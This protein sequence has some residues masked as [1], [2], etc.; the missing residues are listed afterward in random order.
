MCTSAEG[1]F[2]SLLF[3]VIQ[4]VYYI[5]NT[6]SDMKWCLETSVHRVNKILLLWVLLLVNIHVEFLYEAV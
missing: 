1:Y 2:Y 6:F 5:A 3:F 4:L